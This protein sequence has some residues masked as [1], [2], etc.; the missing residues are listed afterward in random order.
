L[1]KKKKINLNNFSFFYYVNYSFAKVLIVENEKVRKPAVFD[2][3]RFSNDTLLIAI[4]ITKHTNLFTTFKFMIRLF[5][6]RIATKNR[7]FE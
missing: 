7:Q 1:L 5:E 4:S 2:Y 6:K 3:T